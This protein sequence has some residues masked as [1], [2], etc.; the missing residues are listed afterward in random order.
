MSTVVIVGAQWGDEGKGKIIDYLA[1]KADIVARGQGG[2]NAG[3]TVV[4]EDQ[5]YA[6]HL[7]PS[8]ILNP[9]TLNVI[10]NGVVFDPE[11]FLAEIDGLVARGVDV[12]TIRVS[13]R[14]HVIFP[15]HKTIDALAEEARGEHQIGTT[16]KGIGPCY[17]DKVERSGIRM[18]DFVDVETFEPLF[19]RNAERKNEII[20][21]L[22]GGE[23]LDIDEMLTSYRAFAERVRPFVAETTEIMYQA[24]SE[25]K[26]IL[27]EGAQG[28]LLDVDYGTYPYVTSSHPIS[29]GFAI[30]S[31][32]GPNKIDE[33]LGITKAYTTRVGKGPFVTELMDATGDRIRE[34]GH[35]FGTTTGRPRRCGWFDANLVRYAAKVNGMTSMSLMLLDVLTGFEELKI[36]T[37]YRYEGELIT[38][39]PSSLRVLEACE[40]VYETL[41]G[42]Q[43]D[44]T[45][46]ER[47]EELPAEARAYVERI[48]EI[49]GVPIA[50]VSIGPAR[51]Q[52]LIRQEIF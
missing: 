49:V 19:R 29:G 42:W 28:T 18:C 30:G 31:G 12:S 50:M 6:L 35:E 40:P 41:P 23:P 27:L 1:Q 45:G 48:E 15:Y 21:K 9:K 17:M 25:N 52:T 44:L 24:V 2:N 36:C 20:V 38:T 7:I 10:G 3:H 14:A 43:E 8:G 34:Q 11:G 39:Y 26:K 4:V 16:K 5:K 22:Y 33:V 37:G 47:Y 51:R 32:I 13:D 46:V